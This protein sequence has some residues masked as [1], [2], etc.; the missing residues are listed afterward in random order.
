MLRIARQTLHTLNGT[1]VAAEVLARLQIGSRVLPPPIFMH[2][3]SKEAWHSLD[4][5]VIRMVATSLEL[6]STVAPT[7]VNVSPATLEN[8]KYLDAFC[9]EIAQQVGKRRGRLVI[10]IP[11]ASALDGQ[12]LQTK[13]HQIEF[14]GAHVAIDDFG[15][16]F[17]AQGRLELHRWHY[18][19]VDLGAVQE[20]ENLNWLDQAIRYSKDR[21]VQIIIEKLECPK[22][23]ELLTPVKNTAWYQGYCY[24]RPE[25][26]ETPL[27]ALGGRRA[28]GMLAA[29]PQ[30]YGTA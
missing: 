10:E 12:E 6:R 13:L 22:T 23:L 18:C 27:V 30:C 7:F 9:N 19:K 4:M 24:S 2:G 26:L 15:R 20:R 25:L 29:P 16:E 5:E 11:E 14:A 17:A 3:S 8:E 1:C 28:L 21:G